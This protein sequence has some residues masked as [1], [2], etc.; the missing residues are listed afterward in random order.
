MRFMKTMVKEHV[1]DYVESYEGE[2]VF[3][4][5]NV[6]LFMSINLF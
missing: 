2:D 1:R 3:R 6:Q 4:G 5:M